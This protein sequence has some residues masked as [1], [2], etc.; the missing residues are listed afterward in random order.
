MKVKDALK[1]LSKLNPDVGL[2]VCLNIDADS[3]RKGVNIS[4]QSI[5][6]IDGIVS[7]PSYIGILPSTS[8]EIKCLT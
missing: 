5:I 1:I 3:Y 8:L 4:H 7:C 2:F 6:T